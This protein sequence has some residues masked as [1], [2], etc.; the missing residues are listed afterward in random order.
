MDRNLYVEQRCYKAAVR[1][2]HQN[3]SPCRSRGEYHAAGDGGEHEVIRDEVEVRSSTSF[4]FSGVRGGG[5]G[6]TS[7]GGA[8][9]DAA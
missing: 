6:G 3:R 5:S 7:V 1:R 4:S 2:V 8:E 9:A